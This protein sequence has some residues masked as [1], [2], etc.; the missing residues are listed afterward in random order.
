MH[1]VNSYVN[2]ILKTIN[3]VIG[4]NY[5]LNKFLSASAWSSLGSLIISAESTAC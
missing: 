3:N 5:H 4:A 2:D 1:A